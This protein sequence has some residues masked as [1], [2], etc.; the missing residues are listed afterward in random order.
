ML[1]WKKEGTRRDVELQA[2]HLFNQMVGA[3]QQLVARSHDHVGPMRIEVQEDPAQAAHPL[4]DH[5][6][7]LLDLGQ[8]GLG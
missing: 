1:T 7:E 2:P 8:P 6:D 3:P 4:A 5:V